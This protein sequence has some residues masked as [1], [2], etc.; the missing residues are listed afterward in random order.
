MNTFYC[1][2]LGFQ[3][4]RQKPLV[5]LAIR[6]R[7]EHLEKKFLPES[8]L[9]DPRKMKWNAI[10]TSTDSHFVENEELVNFRKSVNVATDVF[11]DA[12]YD[13]YGDFS[14]K[15]ANIIDF[16]VDCNEPAITRLFEAMGM[17]RDRAKINAICTLFQP[18][19]VAV[20]E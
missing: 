6:S 18:I 8:Q 2:A 5:L 9:T 11:V 1:N 19:D 15:G 12:V 13:V 7:I 16:Y 20:R 17:P 14:D 4:F 3:E 10:L